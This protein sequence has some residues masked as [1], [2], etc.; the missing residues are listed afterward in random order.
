MLLLQ[1]ERR[2]VFVF[3]RAYSYH[4]PL[5]VVLII[6]AWNYPIQ[7]LL[8]PLVGAIAAGNCAILKPSEYAPATARAFFHLLPQYL[9]EFCPSM[10]VCNKDKETEQKILTPGGWIQECFHIIQ[11]GPTEMEEILS[12]RFDHI[13]FTG[14]FN[15]GRIIHS[16]ANLHLTPTTLELGGKSPLYFDDS[17]KDLAT[18][19]R[20]IMWAKFLNAGQTCAAPDYIL[21]TRPLQA[22]LVD[23]ARAVLQEFYGSDPH[24]S[25]DLG[26]IISDKHFKRLVR[27]LQSGSV[28]VGGDHNMEDRYIAPTILADV[29]P[30]DP[31]MQEEI[32]GPILPIVPVGGLEEAIAL[33]NSR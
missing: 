15:I 4:Q 7:L 12:H 23:Q 5:G 28:A 14:S 11:G 16:A 20:R 31:V 25:P 21:C 33:I 27:L 10:S 26:R 3:D 32:F 2:I 22:R 1:I 24:T 8:S 17:V 18:A 6:G 13:F 19:C 29:T 9:D 30:A